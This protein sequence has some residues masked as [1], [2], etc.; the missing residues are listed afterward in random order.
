MPGNRIRLMAAAVAA[1]SLALTSS[2][3]AADGE[4][5]TQELLEQIKQLQQKVE[6]LE[7]KQE[8]NNADVARTVDEIVKDAERRSVMLQTKPFTGN[9]QSGKFTLQSE[10][11]DFLLHPWFQ[12]QFR[13][14][15]NYRENDNGDEEFDNGFEV[16]RMK[17]GFDGNVFSPRTTYLFNWASNRNGG[18]LQLEEAWLRHKLS[19][20]W[21]IKGGQIKEPFAHE[22][23]VSSKRF[24]AADRTL[25]T[26][27]F[28]GGDNYAQGVS[29]QYTRE[30][31]QAEVAFTDGTNS[32]NDNFQDF[33]TNNWDYG[34][35]GRVQYK[36]YGDW[37]A[38]DQFSS[39]AIKKDLA[40]VG[41][42]ADLSAAGNTNQLLHT[43]DIQYNQQTGLGLFGAY[44][45][46]FTANAPIEAGAPATPVDDT[47]DWGFIAQ[48]SYLIP[49]SKWEPFIRYD[50]IFFDDL[51]VGPGAE[52]TVHEIT[53][54]TNYYIHGHDLKFTVDVLWLPNGSPVSDN[55]SG[56]LASEDT[57]FVLRGQFQLLL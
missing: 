45:G 19:D 12:L 43:V 23:L 1:V 10:D 46:R 33:P 28:T 40:V 35:A 27:L 56:V 4:P 24:V 55:G 7:A 38:Y 13:N 44:Y 25:L 49:D 34:L 30:V 26:N 50:C 9:W 37:S 18:N 20:A 8:E 39:I 6:K 31:L 42:G 41:V 14:V 15:T 11:G 52:D 53:V 2:V 51:T 32:P 5:T 48:A 57:Q 17:I 29:L 47:Y 22:S 16:R 36:F 21:A 54:G 3:Y